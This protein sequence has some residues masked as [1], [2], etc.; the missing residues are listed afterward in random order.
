MS[1]CGY[2]P[3]RNR[4]LCRKYGLPCPDNSQTR[5]SNIGRGESFVVDG[6]LYYNHGDG[7]AEPAIGPRVNSGGDFSRQFSLDTIVERR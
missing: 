1:Y 6:K 7:K 4:D 5:L 3:E 2:N